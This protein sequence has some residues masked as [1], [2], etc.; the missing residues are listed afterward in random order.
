MAGSSIA[1]LVQLSRQDPAAGPHGGT[2]T[3]ISGW[4]GVQQVWC[5][6]AGSP[7]RTGEEPS[8]VCA[9]R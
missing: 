7:P 6:G 3:V 2:K 9:N 4:K 1:E 8:L 5:Y